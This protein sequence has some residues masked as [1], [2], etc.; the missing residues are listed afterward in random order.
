MIDTFQPLRDI[1]TD[2]EEIRELE[3]HI[4]RG[5]RAIQDLQE[6][7]Y[8]NNYRLGKLEQEVYKLE[9]EIKDRT[10]HINKVAENSKIEWFRSKWMKSSV[11][12]KIEE[13][14]YWCS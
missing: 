5:K 3:E 10:D 1:G 13:I 12:N 9:S 4:K 6:A 2:N 14:R 8:K 11:N 7:T